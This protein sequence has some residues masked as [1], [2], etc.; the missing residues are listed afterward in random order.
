MESRPVPIQSEP[1]PNESRRYNGAMSDDL[2]L[3][4]I[5]VYLGV[6]VLVGIGIALRVAP[7]G[8]LSGIGAGLVVVIYFVTHQRPPD[9]K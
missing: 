6:L 7:T 3:K 8:V 2:S 9:S 4:E 5:A 1:K